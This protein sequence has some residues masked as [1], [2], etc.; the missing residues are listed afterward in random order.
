[1]K[2]LDEDF[3]RKLDMLSVVSRKVIIGR[4]KGEKR[5]KRRG[6][7]S[8]FAEHRNYSPGDDTRFLDWNIYGRLNRLFLKLFYEEEDLH[9]SI[10]V[11]ASESMNY[12]SPKKF[13]YARRLAAALGYI[14]ASGSDRVSISAFSESVSDSLRPFRGK[15]QVWRMFDFLESLESS[16]G[17]SLAAAC[18]NF[19]VQS[20]G[21]G[22]TIIISDF[23]DERG[24]EE[25]LRFFVA[26]NQDMFVLH[27]L[28][29]N[30]I[31]PDLT[32]DLKLLDSETG[33]ETEVSMSGALLKAY[34]RNVKTF[35][36][37]LKDYCG[38]RG[39]GYLFAAT[40][41]P[42]EQLVLNYLRRIGLVK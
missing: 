38:R 7:S 41:T 30:E 10:L 31:S 33:A 28:S 13:D 29:R 14:A 1:M 22:V 24:Y 42:F 26:R 34:D 9:V 39:L 37:G 5:S 3:I 17:T 32:G 19:A 20:R 2:L 11:D 35:C 40:D 25:A 12:G 4:L 21:K 8:E 6:V 36:R 18:R 27:L 15:G 23:L 16:G